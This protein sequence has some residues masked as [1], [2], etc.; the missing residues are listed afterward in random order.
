MRKLQL[1]DLKVKSFVTSLNDQSQVRGG[2]DLL[3]PRAS[4]IAAECSSEGNFC[5]TEALTCQIMSLLGGTPC[6][7]F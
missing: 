7:G 3:N 1:N 5:G 6:G 4:A 2:D